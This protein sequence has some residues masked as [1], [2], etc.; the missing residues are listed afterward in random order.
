MKTRRRGSEYHVCGC[1]WYFT[2]HVSITKH[3]K[4]VLIAKRLTSAD[5]VDTVRKWKNELK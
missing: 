4:S 5:R 1:V 3:D 2:K